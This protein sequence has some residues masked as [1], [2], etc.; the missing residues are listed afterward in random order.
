MAQRPIWRGH[1]RL[2]L[3]S[4]PVALYSVLRPSSGLHFHLINPDTGNRIR[5]VTVDSETG[6]ELSRSKL[7]KGYEYEKDHYILLDDSDFESARIE[8]SATIVVDSFVPAESIAPIYFE[9]S[10]Y[11]APDGKGGEDVYAVLREAIVKSKRVAL[12]RVVINRRERA[13][14]IGP[15]EGGMVAHA[16]H[17]LRDLHSA[18]TLF[19]GV[20]D[21]K[22]DPEMVSLAT[23]L[24]DRQSGTFNPAAMEDRYESRLR[25]VIDAKLKGEGIQPEAPDDTADRGNVIDLMAAL[26]KSLGQPDKPVKAAAARA[27]PPTRKSAPGRKRKA[28]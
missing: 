28:G 2:A 26:R 21:T 19:D 5:M 4:C 18:D 1:L 3:V 12:S 11:L 23:Q 22:L 13:I 9:A 27:K 10:Y 16:L 20:A 6:E 14:A 17:E 15:A 25:E 8:S 24:I 7:V